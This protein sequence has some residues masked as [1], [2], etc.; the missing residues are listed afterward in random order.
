MQA[1]S[2]LA[3]KNPGGLQDR[4]SHMRR[5]AVLIS[6]AIHFLTTL[7]G[8][9]GWALVITALLGRLLLHPL[10]SWTIRSLLIMEELNPQT[11]DLRERLAHDPPRLRRELSDLFKK[12]GIRAAW[13]PMVAALLELLLLFGLSGALWRGDHLSGWTFL[14]IP[15]DR[16]PC[17]GSLVPKPDCLLQVIRNPFLTMLVILVGATTFGGTASAP[18]DSHYAWW[19]S[20]LAV[21][22]TW[23]SF[24]IPVGVSLFWIVW[25]A[26]GVL[27]Y[28][29]AAKRRP[30]HVPSASTDSS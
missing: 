3:A 18:S 17:P 6:R 21:L 16:A 28:T 10:K 7:T 30:S 4:G 13:A 15:L 26:L 9:V 14:G 2:R 20:L 24:G 8:N 22:F 29:A 19:G 27:E 25:H 5:L 11:Q 23:L 12:S 1:M